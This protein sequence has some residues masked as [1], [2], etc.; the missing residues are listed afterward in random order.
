ME[1]TYGLHEV[2]GFLFDIKVN[3]IHSSTEWLCFESK[4]SNGGCVVAVVWHNLLREGEGG[5]R[6]EWGYL[7]T[8][9]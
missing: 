5:G 2:K 6:L 1:L 3:S 9:V 7:R 4:G 8:C